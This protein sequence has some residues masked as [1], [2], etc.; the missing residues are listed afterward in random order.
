MRP[1][2]GPAAA[3]LRRLTR[4]TRLGLVLAAGNRLVELGRIY[5]ESD[6]WLHGFLPY[7]RKHC[8]SRRFR[9]NLILEIGVGG[10]S[11]SHLGGGSLRIWRDYFPRSRIIGIDIHPKSIRL[12]PRVSTALADQ[13]SSA[14]LLGILETAG[15]PDII[16]DDGSHVGDDVWAS[17]SILW[18]RLRP[19]G[20]YVI[21]DLHTSFWPGYGGSASPTERTAVGLL[22]SLLVAVQAEDPTFAWKKREA[23]PQAEFDQVVGVHIYPGI[24]FVEKAGR[25]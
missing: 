11:D 14:D 16:I 2:I 7:Y 20:L 10:D 5:V 19:G 24:A 13:G 15:D 1:R 18:P 8:G 22:R 9:R 12:G 3:Q 4:V 23:T 6:K 21:E 17:F 25:R